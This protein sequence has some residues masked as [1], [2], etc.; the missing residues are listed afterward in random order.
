MKTL[1]NIASGL[2]RQD[3]YNICAFPARPTSLLEIIHFDDLK[4]G[5]YGKQNIDFTIIDTAPDKDTAIQKV[6]DIFADYHAQQNDI[7]FSDFK[8]WIQ[9]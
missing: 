1:L 7:A 2:F 4:K 9:K 8:N 6:C 5:I 3:K